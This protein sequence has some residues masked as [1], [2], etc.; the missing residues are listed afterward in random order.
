MTRRLL[1]RPEAQSEL[2]DA[3]V[4]YEEQRAGLGHLFAAA[5]ETTIA[6]ILEDPSAYPRVYGDTRR[7]LVNRFSYAR[8]RELLGRR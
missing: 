3:R 7:A 1:F 5:V 4:W 8:W 2:L 6:A